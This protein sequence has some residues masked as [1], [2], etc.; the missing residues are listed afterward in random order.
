MRRRIFL[1]LITLIIGWVGTVALIAWASGD[2]DWVQVPS[3]TPDPTQ[4]GR[5]ILTSIAFSSSSNG[6]A[7]GYYN[8]ESTGH[9]FQT[10]AQHWDGTSWDYTPS[11]VYTPSVSFLYGVSTV[12]E[13]DG[14]A[15]GSYDYTPHA[16]ILRLV[17]DEW[18]NW[19]VSVP[20]SDESVLTSVTVNTIG[21]TPD[22]DDVWAAGYYL[23]TGGSIYKTLTMHWDGTSWSVFASP[24]VGT[25]DNKLYGITNVPGSSNLLWA[26]GDYIDGSNQLKTLTMKADTSIAF[27]PIWSVVSSYN[28][29]GVSNCLSSVSALNSTNVWAVGSQDGPCSSEAADVEAIPSSGQ[30]L[31]EKWTGSAWTPEG[32]ALSLPDATTLHG[33]SVASANLVWAVGYYSQT[34]V[35]GRDSS[36]TWTQH[37]SDSPGQVDINQLLGVDALS[38]TTA[39]AA[40][41]YYATPGGDKP[42]L[43]EHYVPPTPTP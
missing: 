35:L 32:G 14:W 36:G 25:N 40:G 41:W 1:V 12:S 34:L 28:V 11:Y 17:D 27:P 20:N 23:P 7:V 24:N 4:V 5:K 22:A 13:S 18:V 29:T 37:G 19:S 2:I 10:Q 33:V 43:I 42:T 6:N 9:Y 15:V 30:P 3:Y 8:D 31:I 39:W 38:D 26:V 16:L 21:S